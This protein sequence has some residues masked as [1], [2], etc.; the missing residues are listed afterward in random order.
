LFFILS[1]SFNYLYSGEFTKRAFL[2]GKLDATEVEGLAD[3]LQAETEIQRRQAL[4]Q[5]SG[6]LGKMY[7]E[8]RTQIVNHMAH[9]E[10]FIDFGEDQDIGSK[11]L[12]NLSLS[13]DH[14]FNQLECHLNDNR[15]GERTRSGVKVAI[16]G[17]PNVGKSSL[18]N[19]LSN[20][21]ILTNI[22]THVHL[23]LLS[24]GRS[25]ASGHC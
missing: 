7:N 24:F 25:E 3:L 16:V 17:E 23:H 2:A 12:E 13:I 21:E 10:A 6:E 15:R 8:W 19:L 20:N 4:R 14:L 11:V 1:D 9:L 18:L 5:A 22:F